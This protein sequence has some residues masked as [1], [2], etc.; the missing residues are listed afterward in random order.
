MTVMTYGTFQW[1]RSTWHAVNCARLGHTYQLAHRLA[2]Q[3]GNCTTLSGQRWR[4]CGLCPRSPD[5]GRPVCC[6]PARST[7]RTVPL[8]CPALA[9]SPRHS[10]SVAGDVMIEVV[11]FCACDDRCLDE[12][13]WNLAQLRPNSSGVVGWKSRRGTKLSCNFRQRGLWV[14]CWV[15]ISIL[16]LNFVKIAGFQ[17]RIF[18]NFWSKVFRQKNCPTFPAG[19]GGVNCPPPRSRPPWLRR[20]WQTA[21]M[22]IMFV[23][24]CS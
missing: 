19:K 4:V 6:R 13:I 21:I 10:S 15:K 23:P 18:L 12:E 24:S 14:Q 9:P 2:L 7:T 11:D 16:P 5:T 20:H 3:L 22:D 8:R 17:P 1:T